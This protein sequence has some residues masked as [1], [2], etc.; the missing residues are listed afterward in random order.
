LLNRQGVVKILDMGLAYFA[1]RSQNG[2]KGTNGHSKRVVGTDDYLAPEQVVDSDDV[3]IRADIYGLGATFYYLLTAQPPFG[4]VS[5][6]HQKLSGHLTR[7]PKPVS[8][9]RP[10][11]PEAL[12]AILDRLLA[13][14]PWERYQT[15]RELVEALK[16]WTA[17]PIGPPPDQEFPKPC[18]AR[19]RS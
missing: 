14:N 19:E 8:E 5:L 17:V 4:E 1:R 11:V 2:D 12:G 9:R 15:P 6:A 18:A 16:P 3:D 10:E 7:R 13:K